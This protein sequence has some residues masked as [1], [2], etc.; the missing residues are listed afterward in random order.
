MDRFYKDDIKVLRDNDKA[1][2]AD[3]IESYVN[4]IQLLNATLVSELNA[5]DTPRAK[6]FL[7]NLGYKT[8]DQ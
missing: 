1:E 6:W 7:N 5:A 2:M 3:D 4:Y 8:G